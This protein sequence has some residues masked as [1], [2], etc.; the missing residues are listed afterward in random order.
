MLEEYQS[1]LEDAITS[2]KL[3]DQF[4]KGYLRAA[5]CHLMLG[6]PSLSMDYY[7]KVLE[8]APANKQAKQEVSGFRLMLVFPV[9]V[10]PIV[11]VFA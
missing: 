7:R 10:V 1:A 5:K 11:M 6:N 4:L 8:R 2:I 9:A 3:D